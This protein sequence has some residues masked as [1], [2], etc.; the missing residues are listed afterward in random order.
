M[1]CATPPCTWPSTISGLTTVPTVVHGDVADDVASPVS[2]STSTTLRE[3]RPATRSSAGRRPPSP[4]ASAPCRA[5]GCAQ[6]T[7]TRPHSWIVFTL[8]GEPLTR[9]VPASYSRSSAA[10]SS[11]CATICAPCRRT[12]SARERT[13]LRTDAAERRSVRVH[14]HGT[15]R[16]RRAAPRRRRA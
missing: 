12:F 14:A 7:P 1:P 10:T 4:P 13:R 15:P 8:S 5:A 11:S 3:R 6:R 9:N 2:V 16:C